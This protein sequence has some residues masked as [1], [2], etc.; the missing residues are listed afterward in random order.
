[1][2]LQKFCGNHGIHTWINQP[3][4]DGAYSY[5]TDGKLLIRVPRIDEVPVGISFTQRVYTAFTF[6][7]KQPP[8]VWQNIPAFI[9]VYN[10]CP[11][12]HGKGYFRLCRYCKG[13]GCSR[14]DD[15]LYAVKK[16][17]KL[18]PQEIIDACDECA[19]AGSVKDPGDIRMVNMTGG[20]TRI[21]A[22]LLDMIKDLPNVQIAPYDSDQAFRFKFDGGDGLLMPMRC[23]LSPSGE[24]K[25]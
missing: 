12:C 25:E 20:I 24:D 19:G 3:F 9:L 15:G 23:L 10:A 16:S 22:I 6:A 1:M 11:N 2:D 18:R 14:C 7:D 5:A 4:S 21:S 8:P 13:E 17:E